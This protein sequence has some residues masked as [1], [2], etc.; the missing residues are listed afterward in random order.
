MRYTVYKARCLI[1]KH[2]CSQ[3]HPHNA[4]VKMNIHT[5]THPTK[6]PTPPHSYT[7]A[8]AFIFKYIN[9]DAHIRA[10]T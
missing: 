10:C 9:K 1:I 3:P 2:I 8:H 7:P 5:H 6:M 4:P